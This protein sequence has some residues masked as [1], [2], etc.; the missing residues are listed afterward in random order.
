MIDSTLFTP[1]VVL[2]TECRYTPTQY[3]IGL[4]E[5][6][7]KKKRTELTRLFCLAHHRVL[8]Q[9]LVYTHYYVHSSKRQKGWDLRTLE[10]SQ[11]FYLSYDIGAD[12]FN[13][14]FGLK[15]DSSFLAAMTRPFYENG[16]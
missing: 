8:L 13:N 3:A 11:V 9:P 7:A 16:I 15:V 12:L 6:G 1:S 4:A 10:Q 5:Q 2:V 14:L